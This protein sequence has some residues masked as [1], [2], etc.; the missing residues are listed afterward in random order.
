[1]K[2]ETTTV[3]DQTTQDGVESVEPQK[4][5]VAYDTYRK[6][7]GE[8]KKRDEQL[9]EMADRLKSL[10]QK[11]LE[12][13]GEQQKLIEALRKDL[14][15]KDQKLKQVHQ[16]FAWNNLES[17]LKTFA[18]S[19]GCKKPD[20][21]VRLMDAQDFEGIEVND[22]YQVNSDDLARV[23]NKYKADYPEFF[24]RSTPKIDD[25]S[26]EAKPKKDKPNDWRK[27]PVNEKAKL[28][29][30]LTQNQ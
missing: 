17:Q 13:K 21:L 2:E 23:V 18:A 20:A 26:P 7:L 16:N 14:S 5:M 1:M 19:N 9:N 29:A 15:E 11:E 3:S 25:L 8:K 27:L 24:G 30:K 22:Q 12:A 4:D 28:L 10:E 6:V